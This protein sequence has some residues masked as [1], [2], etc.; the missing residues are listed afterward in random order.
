L[1]I[2]QHSDNAKQPIA[3]SPGGEATAPRLNRTNFYQTVSRRLISDLRNVSQKSVIRMSPDLKHSICKY[4]DTILIDGSTC[5]NEIENRSKDGKKPWADVL[6]CKCNTCG[7]ARRFPMAHER[8][9]RRI[10][11]TPKTVE[12]PQD[13]QIG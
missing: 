12:E 13:M 5:T 4:C 9:K 7:F 2:Q 3:K 10:Y 11:R 6:V 8:Q 1:A